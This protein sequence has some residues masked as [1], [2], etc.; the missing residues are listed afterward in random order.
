MITSEQ[1]K[2]INEVLD[3]FDANKVALVMETLEWKWWNSEE[4]YPQPHE[5]RKTA[6]Y[7]LEES[8]KHLN[9]VNTYG[10]IS[11]K[12]GRVS[13]AKG[14]L[15]V[16]IDTFPND[17]DPEGNVFVSLYFA[18]ESSEFDSAWIEGDREL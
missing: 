7:L 14:G 9:K 13:M 1:Q 18:A 5:I 12:S 10:E 3:R 4:D 2:T 6:R 16:E 17:V 15:T 8:F 11:E